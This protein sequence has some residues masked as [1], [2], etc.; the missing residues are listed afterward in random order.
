MIFLVNFA[1]KEFRQAQKLNSF[2][3][4]YIGGFNKVFNYNENN[5]NVKFNP[6]H[7]RRKGFANYFWKS[8]IINKAL[9]R[10]EEEEYLFYSDSGSIFLKNINPLV[11]DLKKSGKHIMAFKLP[12]LEKQWTKKYT[13]NKI[14]K[15][16]FEDSESNQFLAGFILIRKS[17]VSVKFFKKF[18]EYCANNKLLFDDNFNNNENNDFIEHRHDQSIFSLMCK[19]NKRIIY[20]AGDLSD[21]GFFPKKYLIRPNFIYNSKYTEI[22][23]NKFKGTMLLFRK[24]NPII[25]LIKYTVKRLLLCLNYQ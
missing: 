3:G 22:K 7:L 2:T 12:L 16:H 20:K 4:K 9:E 15:N 18:Q 1:T 23:N 5:L 8:I 21:Y 6:H 25:Y 13:I 24:E 17:K 19:S 14:S 10:I 11:N